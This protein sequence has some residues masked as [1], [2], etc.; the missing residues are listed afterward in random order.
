MRHLTC[1]TVVRKS[2]IGGNLSLCRELDIEK[3]IKTPLMYSVSCLYL[4]TLVVCLGMLS[5]PKPL[6]DNRTVGMIFVFVSNKY[7]CCA[8]GV[9]PTSV[10]FACFNAVQVMFAI[11]SDE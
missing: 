9:H 3:L 8:L 1:R 11:A 5:P 6:H 4:G 2:L 10:A 7:A